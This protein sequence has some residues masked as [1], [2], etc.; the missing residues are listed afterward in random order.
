MQQHSF[1]FRYLSY[2]ASRA[3]RSSKRGFSLLELLVVIVIAGVLVAI[4]APAWLGF[5]NRQ[6]LSSSQSQV[7]T[8]LKT[9]QSDAKR[10]KRTNTVT[11]ANVNGY[12]VLGSSLS[13]QTTKLDDNV[14]VAS[15]TATNTTTSAL[16]TL[17]LPIDINFDS[18]GVITTSS[19]LPFGI[20][21]PI[22]INLQSQ[23]GGRKSCVIVSTLLGAINNRS[24][25]DC[26]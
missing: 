14:Q 20:G 18:R 1:L 5:V 6:K 8:A 24:D 10:T 15:V 17:S 23:Q 21:T 2:F 22:Q 4:V 19:S 9:A 7:F 16:V 25:S 26:P 3:S 12:G 11:I 13:L